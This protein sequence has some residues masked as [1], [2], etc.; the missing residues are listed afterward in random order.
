MTMKLLFIVTCFTTMSGASVYAL[1]PSDESRQTIE[2]FDTEVCTLKKELAVLREQVRLLRQ[3]HKEMKQRGTLK[4]E[5]KRPP[6]RRPANTESMAKNELIQQAEEEDRLKEHLMVI[7]EQFPAED[8]DP[9][10]A[11][12]AEYQLRWALGE[13]ATLEGS[14]VNIACRA[15]LC[16]L[17][18]KHD[19]EAQLPNLGFHLVG[20]FPNTFSRG[21][22]HRLHE[23]SGKSSYVFY[24]ARKGHRLLNLA[25]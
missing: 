9:K 21:L 20:K 8:F 6:R 22:M 18:V 1:Q 16:R 17:E 10:W 12:V 5:L 13:K 15:T 11:Y 7:G 4:A 2:C 19:V 3:Q 24:L 23:D 25:K 14:E